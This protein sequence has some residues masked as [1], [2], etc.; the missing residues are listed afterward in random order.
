MALGNGWEWYITSP[1]ADFALA[2]LEEAFTPQVLASFLGAEVGPFLRERAQARFAA[3]GDSASGKWAPLK[4]VTVDIRLSMNYGGEHPIN[5]R[6]GE[7]ENWV[8]GSGW[9]AYPMGGGAALQFPG[10]TPSGELVD[11]VQTAQKGRANPN[12]QPRPILA[13][14]ET[15]VLQVTTLLAT[16][17]TEAVR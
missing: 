9:N 1:S 6:T 17:I 15:D 3:E 5:R 12:T 8:V 2:K 16:M 7:L 13:I 4:P 10:N 11:K 14:D